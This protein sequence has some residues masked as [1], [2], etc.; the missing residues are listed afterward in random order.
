MGQEIRLRDYLLAH[1][2]DIVIIPPQRRAADI[3]LEMSQLGIAVDTVL[4]E[5]DGQLID[6]HRAPHPYRQ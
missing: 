1:P 5:H 2:V 4:I 3:V 6:F